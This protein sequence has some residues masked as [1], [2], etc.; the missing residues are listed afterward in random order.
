MCFFFPL[1]AAF[2]P[3]LPFHGGGDQAFGPY[4]TVGLVTALVE[5]GDA[6]LGSGRLDAML[7]D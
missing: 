2:P 1:C 3:A 7:E 6:E 5:D 4:G